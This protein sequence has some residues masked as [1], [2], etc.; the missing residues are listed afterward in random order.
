MWKPCGQNPTR[1]RPA[2]PGRTAPGIG[3]V[4]AGDAAHQRGLARAVGAHHAAQLA[5]SHRHVDPVERGGAPEP[6]HQAGGLDLGL[7]GH[8][9]RAGPGRS[10]R[11]AP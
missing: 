1:S 9:S 7:L 6:L 11:R 5:G 8:V 2:R 10:R 4:Q 3:L